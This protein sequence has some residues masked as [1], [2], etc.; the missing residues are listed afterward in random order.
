MRL[1][2][3]AA[4]LLL[5]PS[6][7]LAEEAVTESGGM[8]TWIYIVT[9]VVTL[10]LGWVGNLFRKKVA[11]DVTVSE[12]DATTSLWEQRNLLID[13]RIIPFAYS[14]AVHW[15][16]THIAPILLDLTDGNGFR[17]ADHYQD[18]KVY[19]RERVLQKFASENVDI[20]KHLTGKELDDILDRLLTN[21]ITKLPDNIEAL[22]PEGIRQQMIK[23]AG[24][25]LREKAGNYIPT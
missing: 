13:Q 21:L 12:I 2:Y 24:D 6:T 18:L 4:L 20:L 8:P 7:L 10:L 9:T 16:T 19:V 22:I 17:W 11:A 14:T 23:Y 5:L 15:I 1:P 25:F 3:L